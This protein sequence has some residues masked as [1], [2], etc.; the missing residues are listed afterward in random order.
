MNPRRHGAE[1]LAVVGLGLCTPLGLTARA[2]QVEM[3]AGTVRFFE[4]DVLDDAGEPVRASVLT[5]LEPGLSR[6]ERMASLAATALQEALKDAASL[7]IEQLPLLLSLPEPESGSAF[8]VE[9]LLSVLRGAA[10]PVR[11]ETSKDRLFPEG[12][13]GFF[14]ALAEASRL[15]KLRHASWVLVGGV[16]SM[17]DRESLALHA[18][19]GRALGPANRDGLLPGEGAGFVLLTSPSLPRSHRPAIQGWIVSHALSREPHCFLQREP[20]LAE[21][22]SDALRQLGQHPELAG[23]RVRDVLSCQTGELFWAR[24]F[25]YAYL[26]N[27]EWMPEPLT[28]SLIAKSL[29]DPGAAAG[30]IQLGSGLYQLQRLAPAQGETAQALLYG[31]SDAGEVGACILSSAD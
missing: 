31:C 24:E 20:N 12:R 6:T 14:R 3:A 5:L 16:D 7:D 27:A 9:D 21:G 25:T 22:L 11:L 8:E 13:A 17:C 28:V 26:R 18:R 29:G 15:L 1:E 23:R 19:T 4:T 30:V 10:A 2:T